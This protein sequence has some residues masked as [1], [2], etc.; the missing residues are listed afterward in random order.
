MHHTPTGLRG[1]GPFHDGQGHRGCGCCQQDSQTEVHNLP[2]NCERVADVRLFV[3]VGR[4][5]RCGANGHDL[6]DALRAAIGAP[7][8]GP[9]IDVQPCGCLD[10]CEKA[11]VIV[12]YRGV[13]A[14]QKRPPQGFFSKLLHRPLIRFTQI[15]PDMAAAVIADVRSK[16]K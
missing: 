15:T 13:V 11:P 7:D 9:V 8:G 6:P 2:D 3:C 12:A 14:T 10:D 4:H 5:C 16:W 1:G